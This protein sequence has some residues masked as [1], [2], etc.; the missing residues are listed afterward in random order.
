MA[1][2]NRA[3]GAVPMEPGERTRVVQIE[4]LTDT[5]GTSGYPVERWDP[6][7][8]LY[9]GRFEDRGT[10]R[11]R[12]D[13]TSST[14]LTRWEVGYRSDLDPELVDVPK[15]RRLV[16]QGRVFDIVAASVIGQREGVELITMLQHAQA[17][18]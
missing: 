8:T 16:H 9:A 2:R 18:A 12:T 1:F 3:L 4:Q 11:F 6:L 13:Q 15:T 5:K 7:T 14:T 17:G 10:E